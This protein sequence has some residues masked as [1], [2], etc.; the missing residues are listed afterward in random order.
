MTDLRVPVLV[1]G[2]GVAGLSASMVLSS[3]GV[4]S[5]VV[6]SWPT[7]SSLP[8]AHVIGQRTME[9][10]TEVGVGPEIE[11]RSTPA[12]NMRGIAW[13]AGLAGPHDDHGRKLAQLD[14]WGAGYTD[15]DYVAASASR[16]CN[17]PQI[18]LEPV[19]KRHAE[20]LDPDGVRFHHELVDLTQDDDGV[21]ATVRDRTAGTTYT[22]R[23]DY[24][25]AA[26][27]GRT[28]GGLLGVGMTGP[29]DIM[30]MVSVHMAADLSPWATDD[31]VLIRWLINPAFG[32][33]WSGVLVPM[34]PERWGPAS[35]EW[36]FHMQYATDDPEAMQE[37]KVLAR[38]RATMGLPPELDV[39]VLRISQWVME[40]VIAD[41]FRVGRVFLAGDAAHRHPPTGG[42]GMNSAVHDVH[43]LGWKIAAVLAGRAGDGLLDTYEVERKPV[44]QQNIDSAIASAMNHFAITEALNLSAEKAPEENWA[45]LAPLLHD[46]PGSATRRHALNRAIGAQTMEYRHHNV[47][48]GYRYESTA[49]VPDGSPTPAP[50][51]PV[52]LYEPGTRP[53]DPMPHAVV[54]REG[55][56]VALGSL[57]RGGR[58]LVLAGEEG[59]AWVEA[60][61]KLAVENDLPLAAGTVGV[62]D[63][64]LVDVRCAWLKHRGIAPAGVVVVRPDR[65]VA[66]R[67]VGGV[68]DP[69]TALRDALSQV[70]STGLR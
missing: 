68:A 32:G 35:E 36:V 52:R 12:A 64:D 21:T 43:N 20:M 45:E 24:V 41:R 10:F 58:F 48:F 62:L 38:M 51:D 18:R 13:Y 2:G 53:G 4:E 61:T 65:Y 54:E 42:L 6:S 56:R 23:A 44:D 37:E 25:I 17:L 57:V 19:L 67:S 28:V 5:L 31:D 29:R 11:E 16:T 63:S 46:L 15:P 1:V 47:E 26:D 70:L 39:S 27:G 30:K 14:A 3:L 69:Y 49:V 60:A 50:L 7:T 9:I 22:V 34:G 59:H 55:E 66:Y 8:K 33:A 40:G